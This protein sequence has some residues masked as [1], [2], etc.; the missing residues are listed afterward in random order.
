MFQEP[1]DV[2][3]QELK[4][5]FLSFNKVQVFIQRE[6]LIHPHISGN[7]WRKLKYNFIEAQQKGFKNILTFGGAY[8]NH[9]L[10]VAAAANYY[11]MKSRGIIRGEQ[12]KE[13][14]FTLKKAS[15]FG[16]KLTYIRR[17]FYRNKVNY[18]WS[19]DYPDYYIVPEGGDNELAVK[20]CE[21]ILVNRKFDFICCSCGTGSTIAGI[22]RSM[23]KNQQAIG[24]SALKGNYDLQMNIKKYV[25]NKIK[26]HLNFD[27]NF[28]G[29][30]KVS[31]K[32]IVFINE[33][34]KKYK[35]S[36]DPIYTGKLVFGIFD[37]INKKY[38]RDGSKI[39]IIHTGGLQGIIGMNKKIN[40][41][42]WNIE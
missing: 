40:Q 18:D 8:S 9:I 35:I 13:L 21:E 31:K 5:E 4:S 24:F 7:K 10:A 33:F 41:K 6:D 1:K 37:L 42:G 20:G 28:G 23:N 38:F 34:K 12:H 3:I 32:L 2:L 16:M 25:S 29:Y 30:A 11:K 27:Y 39:L 36:L 15:Y 26:W 22:I 19:I 17:S 14:N